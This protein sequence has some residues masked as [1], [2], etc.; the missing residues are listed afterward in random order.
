MTFD[1]LLEEIKK[2]AE[3]TD[4]A[5]ID[6]TPDMSFEVT[7]TGADGGVFYLEKDGSEVKLVS[8]K[9]PDADCHV[10][11][12]MDDL[13][14]LMNGR[15]NPFMAFMFGKVKFDGDMT[16]AMSITRFIG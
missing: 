5:D 4:Q 1:M 10:A 6:E 8:E 2:R 3:A 13:V 11:M 12:S 9:K 7:V 15:L 14:A 16:K